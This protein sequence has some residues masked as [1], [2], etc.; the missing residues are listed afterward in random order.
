MCYTMIAVTSIAVT[1][2]V[3]NHN[4]KSKEKAA[5]QKELE[6]R[7]QFDVVTNRWVSTYVLPTRPVPTMIT[8]QEE[9]DIIIDTLTKNSLLTGKVSNIPNTVTEL[10]SIPN[11][12]D[13]Y[14]LGA[15]WLTTTDTYNG[16]EHTINRYAL[17]VFY[18]S[19]SGEKWKNNTHWLSP[20]EYYCDWYGIVCCNDDERAS[21]LC[22]SH[23]FGKIIEIDLFRNNL[24]GTIPDVIS[25]FDPS[26][27][28]MYLSENSITGT[29]PGAAIA[30]L[31]QFGTLNVAYNFLTGT[32]PLEL[33]ANNILSKYMDTNRLVFDAWMQFSLLMPNA[34]HS[35][36]HSFS[37]SRQKIPYIFKQ[38]IF[39]VHFQKNF[40]AAPAVKRI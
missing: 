10:A 30:T 22:N 35:L 36:I 28:S 5:L 25:L 12:T 19:L 15:Q 32:V 39:R 3:K 20:T 14:V 13:P 26:L 1:V 18:Y 16:K 27:Y 34:I 6:A 33:N 8:D 2:A 31:S 38:M 24:I 29:L 40:I 21:I 17:A 9:L 11:T 4:Q 23:E 37:Y 7:I